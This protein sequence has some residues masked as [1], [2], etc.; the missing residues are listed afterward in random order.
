MKNGKLAL[1]AAAPG[2]LR[3][4]LAIFLQTVPWIEVVRQVR[5]TSSVLSAIEESRPALV[6]LDTNVPGDEV[7]DMVK[8]IKTTWPQVQCLVL[9]DTIQQEQQAR[10]AGADVSVLKGFP[11]TELFCI[12]EEML[13]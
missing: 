12:V 9:A 4:A 3:D 8:Q 7:P 13:Q 10:S 1:I 11:A 5:H 6:L 2:S